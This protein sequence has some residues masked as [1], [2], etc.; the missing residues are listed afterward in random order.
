M[1]LIN[2]KLIEGVFSEAQKKMVSEITDATPRIRFKR[3]R[4]LS[5][6]TSCYDRA[7]AKG[8]C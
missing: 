5:R 4:F 7:L 6:A 1:P 2:V 3:R 8:R